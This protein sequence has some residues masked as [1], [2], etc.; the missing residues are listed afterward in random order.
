MR[1]NE[2]LVRHTTLRIGGPARWFQ[3]AQ[4]EAQLKGT[5]RWALDRG[6]DWMVVGEGSNLLVSDAGFPGLIIKNEV[7]GI[8]RSG[9][10]ISVKAGTS[11]QELVD[12]ANRI[13][14]AG[15]DRMAGIPGT[16]A[17][18]VYGNAGAYGQTIGERVSS[19]RVFDGEEDRELSGKECCFSYRESVF[20]QDKDLVILRAELIFE[21]G[22]PSTLQ[23]SSV[24]TVTRREVKYPP[25]LL[26]PGSFFKN[27][28]VQD[29]SSAALRQIPP[30]RII[31]GKVPAGYL[32]GVTGARG[33]SRGGVR[34]AAYHGN[35]FFNA[36]GGTARDFWALAEEYRDKVAERFGIVLEPEVQR[37]GC[38]SG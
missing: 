20:K 23:D 35:L 7:R 12:F 19:V 36:G 3:R 11:L 31:N 38:L 6:I 9:R 1:E 34:I 5:V 29:I 16:I 32:L 18:A 30:E 17:G 27:I 14:L 25:G 2:P 15:L 26:C 8:R 22:D 24:E 21:E 10:R 37:V 28:R 13:G 4:T 33:R